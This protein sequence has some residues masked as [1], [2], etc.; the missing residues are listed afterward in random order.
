[1]LSH[2]NNGGIAEVTVDTT[3]NALP[4]VTAGTGGGGELLVG[5]AFRGAEM[6][7]TSITSTII[8]PD[9]GGGVPLAVVPANF[10]LEYSKFTYD[11]AL[12]VARIAFA[13]NSNAGGALA[14]SAPLFT[15]SGADVT[16]Y[17]PPTALYG[18][19]EVA[20]AASS[21]VTG[22]TVS[23]STT[24]GA[25]NATI[26]ARFVNNA[27]VAGYWNQIGFDTAININERIVG[28]IEWIPDLALLT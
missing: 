23:V 24:T 22:R 9:N 26:E 21:T 2:I 8:T 25:G 11:P 20:A 5:A 14:P 15:V 27:A 10:T 7:W 13:V 6:A 3:V 18:T 12:G 17:L 19:G 1:M 4:S 16:R 28:V